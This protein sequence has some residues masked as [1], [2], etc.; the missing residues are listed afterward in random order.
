MILTATYIYGLVYLCW[1]ANTIIFKYTMIY[2]I[3]VEILEISISNEEY[4]KIEKK[5]FK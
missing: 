4:L 5:T 1:L 3:F 2:C